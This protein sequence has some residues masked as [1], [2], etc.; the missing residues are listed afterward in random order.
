MSLY[1]FLYVLAIMTVVFLAT[2]IIMGNSLNSF[3]IEPVSTSIAAGLVAYYY[4]NI[5]TKVSNINNPVTQQTIAN[6]NASPLVED[7]PDM[8]YEKVQSG[9]FPDS[10]T[11]Y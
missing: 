3:G 4:L 2:N 7:T 5:H 8:K 11:Q 1:L 9:K 10:K 6:M